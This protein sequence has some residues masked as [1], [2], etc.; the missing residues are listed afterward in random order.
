MPRDD[1][2][3]RALVAARDDETR[4]YTTEIRELAAACGYRVV[5]EV[6]QRRRE[7]PT[8]GLGRGKA[9]DLMRLAAETDARTVIYDGTLSPGQ[10]FSLGDLCPAGTVVIDGPRLALER[11]ATAT[12]SRA[13]ELQ[14]EL[15]RLRYDLPRLRELVAREG[16]EAVRLRHEGDGRVADVE[17]R[18]DAAERAL[19]GIADDRAGRRARRREAGFDVVTLVGY[20][21]A[22]KSRLCRRLADDVDEGTDVTATAD[23]TGGTLSVSERAFETV[24]TT[25]RRATLDG[26]RTVVTDT[27]GFVDGLPLDTL[28]SFRA[29]LD[30]ARGADCLLLVTDASD[31][32]E[33]FRRK[34]RTTLSLIGGSSAPIVP[35]L[36]KADRVD[37]ETLTE[38]A[39]TVRAV[40]GELT[41]EGVPV[42]PRLRPSVPV[43]GRD[44][45][46]LVDLGA[47]VTEA[48]PTA[49]AEVDAANVAGT[50][51]ALSW[52]YDRGVVDGVTYE[53]DRV[54]VSLSG[55]PDV[56]AEARG[57]FDG[58][59]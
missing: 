49:T 26:R 6:T 32:P 30:A 11:L 47:A 35:L 41:S 52:A 20:T 58:D 42:E 43:S 40:A 33:A 7:D 46:G 13:A 51:A 21:N 23:A 24:S 27:V 57:R 5:G 54:G 9:E 45:S 1:D 18:I 16:G 25:S 3:D 37:A 19:D 29:T 31:A 2:S 22:G 55:R 53:G 36:N 15:A 50:Q 17:R 8:Y 12:D 10:T 56:V 34:L 48:L 44:G 39:T 59:G 38:R 14:L 28:R 4:P